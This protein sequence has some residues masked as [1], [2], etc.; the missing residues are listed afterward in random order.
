MLCCSN[1]VKIL[2]VFV[3]TPDTVVRSV[4]FS[5]EVHAREAGCEEDKTRV[6]WRHV[7]DNNDQ[8]RPRSLGLATCVDANKKTKFTQ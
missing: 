2:S 3:T 5:L 8:T 6:H 4:E 1:S 7:G